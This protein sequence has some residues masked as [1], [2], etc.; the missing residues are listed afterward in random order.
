MIEFA[1][2]LCLPSD[3]NLFTRHRA[4]IEGAA[5]GHQRRFMAHGQRIAN[6]DPV[7]TCKQIDT[8]GEEN[9]ESLPEDL[10]LR[11]VTRHP[12]P[13]EVFDGV[14]V[15]EETGLVQTHEVDL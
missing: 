10:I 1:I 8:V 15:I 6:H 7:G 12:R 13:I 14:P 11:E 9:N 5:I 3:L 2:S 4:V